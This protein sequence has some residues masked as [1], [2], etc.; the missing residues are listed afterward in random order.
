MLTRALDFITWWTYRRW[1]VYCP[2]VN[3]S[4]LFTTHKDSFNGALFH[5]DENFISPCSFHRNNSG[6]VVEKWSP[7][8]TLIG[9][10]VIKDE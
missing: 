8:I 3:V 7:K 6:Q 4:Y 9:F 2:N 1:H 5:H 10:N